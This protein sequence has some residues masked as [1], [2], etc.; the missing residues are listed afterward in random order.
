MNL[1]KNSLIN[2]KGA[3][4][5]EDRYIGINEIDMANNCNSISNIVKEICDEKI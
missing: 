5:F 3:N 1:D 4:D 2:L